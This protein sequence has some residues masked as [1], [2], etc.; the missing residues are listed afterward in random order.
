MSH[1][2]NFQKPL[3]LDFREEDAEVSLFQLHHPIRKLI[4]TEQTHHFF[5]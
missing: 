3:N 4:M 2:L 5:Q 1:L